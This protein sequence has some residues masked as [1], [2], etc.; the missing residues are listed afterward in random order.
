MGSPISSPHWQNSVPW[1]CRTEILFFLLGVSRGSPSAPGGFLRSLPQGHLHLQASNGTLNLSHA[2][3]LYLSPSLTFRLGLKH[4]VIRSGIHRKFF[5]AISHLSW[6]SQGKNAEVVCYSLL[7]WTTFY[8]NSPPCPIHLGWPWTAWLIVW[9]RQG[10]GQCDQTG[11]FSVIVSPQEI[12]KD[13][14]VPV[15]VFWCTQS[16]FD[17]CEHLWQVWG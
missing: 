1:G 7:Q 5:F 2:S 8:Q 9:F 11:Y 16:M 15:S 3:I 13:C 17:P 6:G 4:F 12:L 10:C 14:S